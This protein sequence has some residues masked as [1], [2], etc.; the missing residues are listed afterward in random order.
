MSSMSLN[1]VVDKKTWNQFVTTSPQG[2][3]FC[4]TFFLDALGVEYELLFVK[5]DHFL[6][7]GAVI[8]KHDGQPL[9]APYPFTMYQ[10]ILY[11]GISNDLPLHSK[12]KWKQEMTEFFLSEMETKYN[13]FSFSLHYTVDDLRTFQW[14][15]YHEPQL[16]LF[17]INLRYTGLLDISNLMEFDKYLL[18][19][20]M[21]RRREWRRATSLGLTIE[22]SKDLGTLDQLHQLTFERQG[23]VRSATEKSLLLEISKAA[24]TQGFGEL[25]LCRDVNKKVIS[26]SLFLYDHS[27]AYYLIGANDPKYRNTGSGTFLMLEQICRCMKNG[28]KRIDFLGINSPN[29]GDYKTSFNA[30]PVPY[31]ELTWEKP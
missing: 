21:L 26:A 14:F 18:T 31:F 20:R 29:R 28:I 30:R 8:L 2:T 16:G 13:N 23:M 24:L 11:D 22:A 19:I 4:N 25:L 12:T 6:C 7:L 27:S 10:G 3:I 9:C 15:H 1:S 17:K 5:K